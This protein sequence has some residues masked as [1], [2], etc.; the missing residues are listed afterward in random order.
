MRSIGIKVTKQLVEAVALKRLL[1]VFLAGLVVLTNVAC[2][3]ATQAAVPTE[4]AQAKTTIPGQ[5]MYPYKDTNRDTTAAET[6]AARTIEA[7]KRRIQQV[8]TPQD[9]VEEVA[10][11][12]TAKEGARQI[13][14]SVEQATEELG[15][16]TQQAIKR[17]ERKTERAAKD[18]GQS[19]KRLTEDTQQAVS[20]KA[21]NAGES[22]QRAAEDA[23]DSAQE[24]AQ[25]VVQ[26]T[27]R[28][29]RNLKENVENAADAID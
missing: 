26:N 28:G 3:G 11:V 10:P 18:L 2:A 8:Q 7:E 29:L 5:D 22:V 13:R 16:S 23:G 15:Q 17:A 4:N 12:A 21:E 19:T 27:R 24:A 6:K 1:V 14:N 20:R 9:Y 25:N